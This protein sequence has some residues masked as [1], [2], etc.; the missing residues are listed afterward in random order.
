[1]KQTIVGDSK[2]NSKKGGRC[3]CRRNKKKNKQKMYN[4]QNEG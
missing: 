4:A 1:M 2:E 3:A